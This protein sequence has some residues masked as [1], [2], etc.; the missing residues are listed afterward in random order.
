MGR[1][2]WQS[3]QRSPS[4]SVVVALG[5]GCAGLGIFEGEVMVRV[6]GSGGAAAVGGVSG[7]DGGVAVEDEEGEDPPSFGSS[8]VADEGVGVRG[9][10]GGWGARMNVS[11]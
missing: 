6:S 4:T 2:D 9:G 1:G 7:L 8:G 10:V 5:T 3:R 11:N